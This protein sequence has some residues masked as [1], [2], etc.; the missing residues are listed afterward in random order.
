MFMIDILSKYSFECIVL[1][2]TYAYVIAVKRMFFVDFVILQL[3]GWLA[4]HL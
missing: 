3:A 1:Y 2:I 4:W